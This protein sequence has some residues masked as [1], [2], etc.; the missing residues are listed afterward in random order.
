MA[1]IPACGSGPAPDSSSAASETLTVFAASSLRDAFTAIGDAFT[2]ANPNLTITFNFAGSSELVTQIS[3]GAPADIVATADTSTM[4]RLTT[5][6]SIRT[7]PVV[8]TTNRAMIIVGAGNPKNITEVSD[9]ADPDLVVV[10][11]APDVPCGTYARAVLDNAGVAVTFRSLEENVKSVV[12]KVMLGEADAGIVYVTD[13]LGAGNDVEGVEIS[14]D[15][16]VLAEYPVAVT[17]DADDSAVA[18]AF[19]DFLL[20]A[21]GRSILESFGFVSP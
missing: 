13:V 10:A 17:A 2:A 16:N 5:S 14:A 20:S 8:F 21:E 19:I 6:D 18:R 1:T 11:C 12:S 4:S 9:L 15:I 7:D 3:N